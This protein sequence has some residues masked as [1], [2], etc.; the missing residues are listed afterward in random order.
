MALAPKYFRKMACQVKVEATYGV[1]ATPVPGDNVLMS[2]VT[3][4][5]M[6]AQRLSRDLLLPWLGNQGVI[7]AGI[8]ATIEGDIEIAG[9]GAAGTVPKWGSVAKMSGMAETVTAGQDVTY[10]RVQDA[11]DSATVYFV[12]DKVKHVLVGARANLAPSLSASQ[13]P[14][15]RA[16]ITGLLG[17]IADAVN[18]AV[19]KA[20]WIAPVPVSKENTV[21]TIHGWNAVAESFALNLGNTVTPSFLIGDELVAITAISATGSTVV[22]AA[23]LATIDWFAKAKSRAQAGVSCVHGVTPGNI[24]EFQMPAVE[25]GEPEPGQTDGFL[26]YSMALDI[27]NNGAGDVTII[28]R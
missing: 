20:G 19:S 27:V 28:V 6:V 21:L 25:I 18:P 5:P 16:S 26:N 10:T 22:R 2:N 11:Q 3:F 1:D 13:M 24:V 7:L 15:M 9:A 23:T 4:R 14:R 8:H 12:M 17:T